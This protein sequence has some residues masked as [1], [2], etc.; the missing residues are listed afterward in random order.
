[1]REHNIPSGPDGYRQASRVC[2]D[3][4]V[5]Q[6]EAEGDFRAT[7][8]DTEPADTFTAD[9]SAAQARAA[10]YDALLM[11][12][13]TVNADKL[14]V[15]PDV[16]RFVR[17]IFSAGKPVGMICHAPWT[18]I[19]AGLASGRTM[20][21]FVSIRTD[22]RNAGATVLDE[23]VVKDGRLISS[24]N[25]GDLPAFCAAVVEEFA[26]TPERVAG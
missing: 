3:A 16:Q 17:E 15:D 14:R 12:G 2:A 21:S 23:E 1:M 8:H 22:L 25:P 19:D 6:E 7:N 9:R 5:R 26:K 20:T 11:P 24:R 13:G 10:D 18:L 4:R